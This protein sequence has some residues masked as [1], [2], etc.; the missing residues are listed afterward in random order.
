MTKKIIS[1]VSK[2]PSCKSRHFKLSTQCEIKGRYWCHF[3]LNWFDAPIKELD[4]IL[5][6]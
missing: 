2:C 1:Q 4:F 3:C 6:D 5:V